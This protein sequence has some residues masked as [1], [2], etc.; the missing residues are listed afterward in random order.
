MNPPLVFTTKQMRK[1]DE[2]ATREFGIPTL[3]LMENA[4]K[5]VAGECQK[6]LSEKKI[7]S[8]KVLIL[9][10]SGN[11]GG[12]G[13]VAARFLHQAGI[14]VNVIL[15]KPKTSL[16]AEPL[17]NFRK[18][19]MLGISCQETDLPVIQSE[20]KKS[21]LIV[22][23]IFGTG[24]KRE[25][26]GL[27][28]QAIGAAND[29]GKTIMAID[30]PSGMDADTGEI[31]G[32]CI[33]ADLTVTLAAFKAGFLNEKSHSWTGKILVANIGFPKEL[34]VREDTK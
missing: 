27:I 3:T 14:S 23:A 26:T 18:V 16:C 31:H 29:S 6:I 34:L 20:I 5:A 12:D 15:F 8:P 2:R 7:A 24:L 22:D 10:G 4:G 9:C 1:L 25:V 11:N 19:E 21:D 32:I 13:F 17:V 28:G 33:K 30:I